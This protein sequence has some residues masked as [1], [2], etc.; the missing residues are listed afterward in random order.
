[1]SSPKSPESRTRPGS[2]PR[3]AA[4]RHSAAAGPGSCVILHLREPREKSWGLL[5][6][7]DP[8]GVWVRGIDLASVE[9]WARQVAAGEGETMGLATYFVPYARLE[10]IVLDEPLG[11]V[12]SLAQRFEQITGVALLAHL[13]PKSRDWTQ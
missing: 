6:R 13:D 5:L 9:D 4:Q 2:R 1:M 8:T 11:P 12:P 7:M 3:G 10:K